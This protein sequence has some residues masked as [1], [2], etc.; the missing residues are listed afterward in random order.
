MCVGAPTPDVPKVPERQAAKLP[1]GGSTAQR[2][3][4]QLARRRALMATI[5]TS[6]TGTLGM[7]SVTGGGTGSTT[8]G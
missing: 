2:T 8:L 5:F 4:Q 6:P 7:P 3:D 1:D